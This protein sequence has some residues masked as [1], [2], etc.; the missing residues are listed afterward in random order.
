MSDYKETKFYC[1][2]NERQVRQCTYKEMQALNTKERSL[3]AED[4]IGRYFISTR[5]WGKLD[6]LFET[7]VMDDGAE[8]KSVQVTSQTSKTWEE[9]V[10]AHKMIVA[11]FR[12]RI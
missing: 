1:L 3:V 2:D 6:T 7:V 10:I 9:A 11:M 8:P 4:Q 12:L 5:F